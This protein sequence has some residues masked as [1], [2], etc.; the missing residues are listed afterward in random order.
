[1]DVYPYKFDYEDYEIT[2]IDTP[3][4][5]DTVRGE[6]EVL[7][8]IADWLDITYRN[9][10]RIKLSGIIYM[11]ALTDRRMYGSTLRNL[12]MFR[13][14]CGDEPLQ[15]V[16][17]TTT[18]WGVSEKAG[19]MDKAIANEDQLRTDRDFWQPMIKHGSRMAR[20]ED[21]R[22]S[23]L[24]IIMSLVDKEPVVLQIQHELVDEDKH[25]ID[26]AAG[27]TVNEEIKK[28]E[29]KYKKQL[30]EMQD[31]MKE[32]LATKDQKW[33]EILT[34]AKSSI[35]RL[36]DEN[37]RAQDILQYERR[38][39]TRKQENEMEN[40]RHEL[41]NQKLAVEREKEA[42]E[43]DKQAMRLEMQMQAQAQRF[44]DKV[45]F[46]EMVAQ[47]RENAD[48]VR[49]EDR[50]ALE[51]RIR[52]IQE[53]QRGANKKG[54]GKRLLM[55]LVPSIGKVALAALGFPLLGPSPFGGLV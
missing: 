53:E 37:R 51:A 27:A 42:S 15:N 28:L 54:R 17:L 33:Q 29:E 18:G 10:P 46:D 9:P 7:R 25:L 32:A 22:E 13:Q 23:A 31:D 47:M 52:E 14:L 38:N 36:R 39:T 49:Q 45:Q 55:S 24:E 50:V 41:E 34:D 30:A 21:T 1:M 6:T 48:K 40:L 11:Q 20:F 19:E 12:K 3:G 2:L 26:T 8:D 35:E 5:N 44:E 4:F 43:R 16:I